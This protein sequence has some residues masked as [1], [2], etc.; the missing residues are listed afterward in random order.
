MGKN[1]ENNISALLIAVAII[2][3]FINGIFFSTSDINPFYSIWSF[4]AFLAGIL[5]IAIFPLGIS[6]FISI[7]F[8]LSKKHKHKYPYYFAILFSIL[9][10]FSLYISFA[11]EKY[12]EAIR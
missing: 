7:F 3:N 12:G 11:V 10:L 8:V 1:K 6:A 2:I 4:S 5:G 9:S